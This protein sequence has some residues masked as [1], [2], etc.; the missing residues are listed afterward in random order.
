[1]RILIVSDTHRRQE[2]LESILIDEGPFDMLIHCGDIE[3]AEEEISYMTGVE[4][5]CVMVPGNND[6][7]S[8]LPRERVINIAGL[9]VWITHG[10][11]YYVSMDTS[12]I[13]E[14]ALVR[15]ANIV[16]F[17]H[18]HRPVIDESGPV[19]AINPGSLTY[20]RQAGRRPTYIVMEVEEGHRPQF[21]LEEL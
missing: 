14:E 18:T 7:F 15:G 17:G 6:Y 20:P 4:C 2:I 1:M 21:R 11:N 10:H 3:G 5:A 19:I 13:K 9:N 12:I 8:D 16:M